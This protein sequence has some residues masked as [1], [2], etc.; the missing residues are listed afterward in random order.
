MF[1]IVMLKEKEGISQLYN[2]Y[3]KHYDLFS[4]VLRKERE[5]ISH[6]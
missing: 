5:G 1:C 3:L 2:H 6:F 4:I